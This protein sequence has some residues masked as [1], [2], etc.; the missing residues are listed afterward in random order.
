LLAET[1]LPAFP[2]GTSP[3]T[4]AAVACFAL[5]AISFLAVLVALWGIVVPESIPL[6]KRNRGGTWDGFRYLRE[7]SE[8]GALV[9]LT[10]LLCVFG[11]PLVTLLPA[12]TRTQLG[13]GEQTYSLLVSAL[14]AGALVAALA[15]A[16]FGSTARRGQFLVI[17]AA[18]G[19]LGLM[20][21]WQ[22]TRPEL[23]ALACAAAGFGLILYLSTGQSILQLAVPDD[24][25]GRVLALWAMT[26]SASAPLGHL[27]A[28]H[29]VTLVGIGPVLFAMATGAGLV[30]VGIAML[31]VLREFR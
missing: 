14:G 13:R 26:L 24:R 12:Y 23:A 5:N 28:G 29:A 8:M 17:G 30:S 15:T 18:I 7:R 16:T 3:V 22:A 20:A 27:L 19:T 6:A 31:V 25:R 2:P 9:L 10:L 21:M 4:L 1:V 11:W